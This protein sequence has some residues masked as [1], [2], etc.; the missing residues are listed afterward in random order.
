MNADP[1]QTKI[2][3][4]RK[5][6]A[7][8]FGGLVVLAI[9]MLCLTMGIIRQLVLPGFAAER[10]AANYINGVKATEHIQ[11]WHFNNQVIQEWGGGGGPIA[12]GQQAYFSGEVIYNDGHRGAVTVFLTD[13]W[14]DYL[15]LAWTVDKV[16]FG[17]NP[18]PIPKPY[19]PI[20]G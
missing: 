12:G 8:I 16:D 13:V 3:L 14:M 11:S 5:H 4:R 10:A 2:A 9:M 18:D 7:L 17:T 20:G 15:N 1:T 6:R 19:N